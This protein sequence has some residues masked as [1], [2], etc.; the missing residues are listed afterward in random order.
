MALKSFKFNPDL[1][2]DFNFINELNYYWKLAKACQTDEDI[3]D[4]FDYY[5]TGSN[6]KR[7]LFLDGDP[8]EC[9]QNCQYDFLNDLD[10]N[11]SEEEE[12]DFIDFVEYEI[13]NKKEYPNSALINKFK[14]YAV[15]YCLQD[16]HVLKEDYLNE[17]ELKIFNEQNPSDN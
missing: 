10:I 5:N 13:F 16:P 11:M 6:Y 15:K 9:Y 4:F 2:N 1:S 8:G 3:I 7:A 12:E 17:E 14:K